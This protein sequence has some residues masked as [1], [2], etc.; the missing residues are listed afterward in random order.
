M[1][2]VIEGIMSFRGKRSGSLSRIYFGKESLS[3]DYFQMRFLTFVR[4][5]SL[6]SFRGKRRKERRGISMLDFIGMRFL[7]F[8]R[9]DKILNPKSQILNPKSE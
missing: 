2:N 3:Y 9:N 4:N 1:N 8:V 7:T 5:D 6:M